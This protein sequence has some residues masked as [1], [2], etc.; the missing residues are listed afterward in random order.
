VA[1]AVV[2]GMIL[3]AL[4]A[5]AAWKLRNWFTEG[6]AD[7]PISRWRLGPWPVQ[8]ALVRTRE[9]LVRAFEYLSLLRLGKAAR[10]WNHRQIAANLGGV[11]SAAT[12]CGEAAAR[13]AQAYEHARYAPAADELP[14]RELEAARRDLCL[15]AGVA[16]A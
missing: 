4:L 16:G 2:F 13:L 8:P 9:E 15:L 1:A 7:G 10:S 11:T 5:F 3:L 14:D 6:D 12:E